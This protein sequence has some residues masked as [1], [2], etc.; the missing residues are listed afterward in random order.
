MRG[1]ACALLLASCVLGAGPIQAQEAPAPKVSVMAAQETA[2]R[3]SETFIGRGEAIDK[4]DLVARVSGYLEEVLVKD[5]AEVSEGDLLFRIESSTYEATLE[6]ARAE[7]ARAEANLEL[8]G[9]DLDRKEEL[10]ERGAVP[11]AERDTSRANELVAEAALRAARASVQQAELN[12]SYTEIKAPFSGRAGRVNVSLGEVIAPGGKSL[13]N[14]VREAPIYVT[15]SLNE[16][17]YIDVLQTI[18]ADTDDKGD[19]A[20]LPDVFVILPNN[21]ELAEKGQVAFVDNRI[22]PATGSVAI[23]AQFDNDHRLILDGSFL[24]VG[25]KAQDTQNHI[26]ISQAA[27]QRDQQGPF[28][29]VVEDNNLV[30]QRYIVTGDVMGTEI[31]VLEGLAQGQKVVV[32]GLQRIRPG[33][34]VSP[35]LV[36]K[37]E[38]N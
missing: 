26:T 33:V 30:T 16:K 24:T 35:V 31:I 17:S 18:G 11:E 21:T 23:R 36:E 32:E 6:T 9:L 8:A 12:L 1:L 20:A 2:I 15:F 14:L 28:V 22:D 7:V 4:V 5:G 37:R 38:E 27:I 3:N 25:L 19:D 34:E 13:I 29:L 10:F